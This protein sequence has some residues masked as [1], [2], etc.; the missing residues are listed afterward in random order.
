MTFK[1]IQIE[2]MIFDVENKKNKKKNFLFKNIMRAHDAYIT[3]MHASWFD[4]HAVGAHDVHD[5]GMSNMADVNLHK[6]ILGPKSFV[7]KPNWNLIII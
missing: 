6:F 5:A 3:L 4:V 1:L 2:K 7:F